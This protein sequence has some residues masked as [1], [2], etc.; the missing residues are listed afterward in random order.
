MLFTSTT[1]PA[2]PCAPWHRPERIRR[3]VRNHNR[4]A[5]D[6]GIPGRIRPRQ[7]RRLYQRSGGFCFCCGRYASLT[8]DHVVPMCRGGENT[9]ANI[10]PLCRECEQRKGTEIIDYRSCRI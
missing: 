1:F 7:W 5:R 10:Q 4:R 9:I 2:L 8:I 3:Q 6:K